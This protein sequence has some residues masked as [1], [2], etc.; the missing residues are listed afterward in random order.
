MEINEI[1]KPLLDPDMPSAELDDIKLDGPKKTLG[2]VL[3]IICT[4]I[5]VAVFFC[6]IHHADGSS[7]TI[8]SF[9]Y[10]G[11]LD[12]FGSAIYWI[13]SIVI[14]GNFILHIYCKYI[15]KGKHSNI[16]LDVYSNDSVVHTLFFALGMIYVI[17]YTA[18]L[19]LG[20]NAPEVIVSDLTGGNV[21]PPICKGV[22]GIILVGA[23]FMP[24]LL[25]YGVLEII[26]AILEPLM[27]PLFKVPG[28]AALDA[29]ASFVS[30]SSLGVL[31]TN[32]LWKNNVYTEKE[33][34]A[35]M[36]GFSAV[37]IGF[38][39]LVI[40]TAGVGDMFAK[41][42]GISFIMVF[43]I[44]ILM[45]RIPPIRW[46]KDVY[47]NGREQSAEE[48]KSEVRFTAQTI[49]RGVSRAVKRAGIARG[50]HK[51]IGYSLKDS[52]VIMPQVLTMISGIGVSAMI[53]AEYTPVFTWLGYIF[54]PLLMVCQV[55]DAAAIAPSMPVGL[56]EMFL[57]VLVMNGTAATV[58]ISVK[59]RIFVCLVS[60]VQIIFF[61]ET[62][63]V[64][65]ATKSPV[66]FWE[67]LVCF[68][69]RTLVAIPLAALAIHFLF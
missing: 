35:I 67:L 48:R 33:M 18:W 64:M 10:N 44:E 20:V 68:L 28:K 66:K 16:L 43:I 11:F 63:T 22:F 56:A 6:S 3:F 27:R 30:S 55:P 23:V 53:V 40:D 34:V 29:T 2:I 47:Y 24:F 1:K 61:S 7:E 57:P 41:I 37:S 49:P 54:Q 69:E 4:I 26:G 62:A 52:V 13:L 14:T 60:M 15:D 42:Y 65:L 19:N 5:G 31:I 9:L 8:F 25:N 45:V 32:R 39:G 51:D 50:V 38:A 46:K 36:T 58:A 21:I 12:L 17:V 59:A